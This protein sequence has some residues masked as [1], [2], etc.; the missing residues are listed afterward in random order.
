MSMI[1]DL[2][3]YEMHSEINGID[4]KYYAIFFFYLIEWAYSRELL[5]DEL[6]HDNSFINELKRVRNQE[7][8]C[9]DFLSTQ[10][11]FKLCTSFFKDDIVA[12]FVGLYIDIDYD[13]DLRRHMWS[14]GNEFMFQRHLITN[15][16]KPKESKALMEDI[17]NAFKTFIEINYPDKLKDYF[18]IKYKR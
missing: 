14:Y 6:E 3:S 7:I 5:S 12:E 15:T 10:L 9:F 8:D 4:L 16:Y 1:A 2:D 18:P 13:P 17:D 11:D